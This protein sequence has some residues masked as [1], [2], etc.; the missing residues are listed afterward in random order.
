MKTH[1]K[2]T[3]GGIMMVMAL[4]IGRELVIDEAE[5]LILK[6]I[7]SLIE[8]VKSLFSPPQ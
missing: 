6:A 1:Q 4:D 8:W 5:S 7:R 3:V 2:V